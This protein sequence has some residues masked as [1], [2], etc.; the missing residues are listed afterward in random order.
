MLLGR[1]NPHWGWAA[2]AA[3]L[4]CACL[5][6][7]AFTASAAMA[8]TGDIIA[9]S[10]PAH[11][12]VN[13]G[14]QAGTCKAEPPEPG[15]ELCSIATPEQFFE[16]A[17]AHPNW[18]FTQFII[19]NE[20]P[21]ETPVDELKAV[22]VDLPVGL[23][24]NPGATVRCKLT[25]FEE[26]EGASKCPKGSE[27]GK[28]EVTASL[29]PLGIP[30]PPTAPL[31]E[32]PVYNVEPKPGEAARFG[33][34]LAGNK[35]YLEGDVN[36]AGDY[37]EGFTIHVP[38]AL[39]EALGGILGLLGGEKG[40]ILKNR[41]VFDGRSG[42]G[43]F[44]TTPTTCFGPAYTADWTP[45][46]QPGGPSGHI[47]STFLRAD[48]VGDPDPNFPNGSSFFE[49]PIPPRS[50]TSGPGTEPIECDSI[51]YE[52]TIGVDPGTGQTD[53]PAAADV[54][55][56]VPHLLPNYISEEDEQDSSHTKAATVTLP[57]GMGIN[58]SAATGLQVCTD[59]QFG[60]GTTNPVAC[61]PQSIIGRAKIESEPLKDIGEPQP[62]EALEGN[63]YVGKQLSRDPTS[64][65]EYR[66]FIE[67]KSDRYGISVRLIG[68]VRADPQ[69]GQL[70]TTISEA[71]QVPFTSFDLTFQGGAT[72]V[73][74]SPPTCGPN[75]TT[76]VMTPWSG[77]APAHPSD[78][79]TMSSAPGGG[80]CAKTLAERPFAPGFAD[81]PASPKAGAFSPVSVHISRPDGQQELKGTDIVLPPGMTGKLRGIPYCPEA[82]LAAAS[83]KAGEEEKASPSCPAASQVGTATVA[84][85]TGPAPYKIGGK[86]FLSGPYHGAPLSLAVVTPATAG[87][88]DLGTVVVRVALF[89]NPETAQISAV[90]DPIPHVF[91]GTLLNVRSV[92]L[93]FDKPD[94]TLNPTSCEPLATSG[95]LAGGGA[96]PANPAAFSA[97]PISV[98]FQT[99]DCGAL[100]FRPK[101]FTKL[102][103]GP[104][105]MRRG[106]HPAIRTVLVA[107]EGDANINRAALTLPHS[108]FLDQAH[109]GT[110]C[111][112]VQLAAS[113]CPA[114]SVYGFARAESPLL[115]EELAG[116]VYL[117][118]SDHELPD[119][120]ADLHGQVDIRLRGVIS[121]AKA[122]I[123]TVFANV[124]DVPVSK[125]VLSMKGGK[126]GLLENSRDLCAGKN[127]SFL[128]FKAQN[129]K[130]RKVKRLP[131]RTPGC[132]QKRSH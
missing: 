91:G 82:A 28:S 115:D 69:T 68:N 12:S 110:V 74:S 121:S 29:P 104:K 93:T 132:H 117:V 30:A 116:P 33:L 22:R 81:G 62:E 44:L 77:N 96:D 57:Q 94:F 98:P 35:V 72:A 5:V 112:R 50:E 119:L 42:D 24:V 122:R 114:R 2:R 85:G 97:A 92:D 25:T 78:A 23:S 128:N 15:A 7:T 80:K 64:G 100:K 1:K 124:P 34:E 109:I 118:S 11:P 86:V 4:L 103:G 73:L 63:V 48:S 49:S 87:P 31:T 130:H 99:S 40:L 21:G 17:S 6:V 111:T 66:I 84:A 59:A 71:P 89:V 65:N 75:Q 58:P 14:W 16:T 79:F 51:P 36:S 127:V 45:G 125:F 52:P 8:D 3:L 9:P 106:G 53:S 19:K 10:D 26:K 47:Y 55:I 113:Q 120:L 126:K 20:P 95:T 83:A 18:G 38:A 107:R 67:A 76:A 61:P 102:I 46:Q 123:K 108:Q 88:F 41:L 43:T 37:H 60:K 54:K 129:G 39:P 27:V 105:A 131:L 56:E 13:S 32:V 90:S 101:L 70:S